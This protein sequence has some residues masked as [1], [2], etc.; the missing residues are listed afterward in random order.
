MRTSIDSFFLYPS[1]G[2]GS[3]HAD[4]LLLSTW[5]CDHGLSRHAHGVARAPSSHFLLAH[6]H[7][8]RLSRAQDLGRDGQVDTSHDY[9]LALWPRAQ[10]RLLERASPREMVGA[11]SRSHLASAGERLPV[12]LW[13]WQPCRQARPQE[14]CS[15]ERMHKQASSLVFWP[16]LRA[17]DGGVGRLS[18]ACGLS[19]HCA[20][21]PE[22][23]SQ[24]KCLV[25]RD[26]E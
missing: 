11:G 10:S 25:S 3:A 12:S 17:V 6:L 22:Q 2:D 14:S 26:G 23:L 9:R 21:A 13:R 8:S 18:C 20:E 4:R 24:R 15:A 1:S 16:A 5:L 19:P 7:A